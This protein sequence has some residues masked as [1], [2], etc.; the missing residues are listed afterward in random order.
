MFLPVLSF[1]SD[2][3]EP[4][5][6]AALV[7]LGL[8]LLLIV[9][10]L[11]SWTPD[12]R[13]NWAK[14]FRLK[15]GRPGWKRLCTPPPHKTVYFSKDDISANT[16]IAGLAKR[17]A[18][19]PWVEDEIKK[20]LNKR[21][22]WYEFNNRY[23][24]WEQ[25]VEDAMYLQV[26]RRFPGIA[27]GWAQSKTNRTSDCVLGMESLWLRLGTLTDHSIGHELVHL[28]QEARDGALREE[29]KKH[30]WLDSA[31]MVWRIEGEAIACF[32]RP[33]LALIISAAIVVVVAFF[34]QMWAFIISHV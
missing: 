25:L 22:S 6:R 10:W 29:W 12:G 1:L 16:R 19:M 7:F 13:R 20:V 9:H 17:V 11:A 14:I 8:V 4:D 5:L 34:P 23:R 27:G 30:G 15:S 31:K 26:Y 3:F 32:P 24:K 28:A 2:L 18:A 33:P 21:A